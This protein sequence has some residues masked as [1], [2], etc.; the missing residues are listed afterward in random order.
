M[1][2]TP[3]PT[4]YEK[5]NSRSASLDTRG[6][7]QTATLRFAVVYTTDEQVVHG[8]VQSSLPPTYLLGTQT[9]Y[10]DYYTVEPAGGDVWDVE[11]QFVGYEPMEITWNG[12]T[13]G[14]QQQVTQSLRTV[15]SFVGMFDTGPAP[16]FKNAIGVNGEQIQGV[17]IYARQLA[18]SAT[19]TMPREI[20]GGTYQAIL[21][22][23]TTKVNDK[24]FRG[25]ARGECLFLGASWVD[26]SSA[27]YVECT[28]K[29]LGSPSKTYEALE[30]GEFDAFT[31]E[32]WHYLWF[33]YRDDVS[34]NSLIKRPYAAYVEQVYEYGDFDLLLLGS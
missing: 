21:F 22:D 25:L 28:F 13:T 10:L 20:F 12:D 19:I 2:T 31:K 18:F 27:P 1:S 16:D 24:P 29:F 4:L 33:L 5:W 32:G 14:G 26:K 34:N 6:V 7:R 11:A 17:Q 9:L 23:L 30:I 15:D 3:A 8:L